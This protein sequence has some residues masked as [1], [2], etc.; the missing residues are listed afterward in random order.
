MGNSDARQASL[1]NMLHISGEGRRGGQVEP[2]VQLLREMQAGRFEPDAV[3][4]CADPP[5]PSASDARFWRSA[6]S[7]CHICCSTAP[8]SLCIASKRW[9]RSRTPASAF[10][11]SAVGSSRA[12]RR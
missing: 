10:V 9:P 6:S 2:A 1:P 7:S 11:A 8:R 12:V 5:T 3:A 4:C